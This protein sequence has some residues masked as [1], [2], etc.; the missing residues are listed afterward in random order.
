[1]RNLYYTEIRIV[2]KT[3]DDKVKYDEK[4]DKALEES[5]YRSRTEFVQEKFRN[6]IKGV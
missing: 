1:M 2:H 5:G 3:H 4:V 6:L